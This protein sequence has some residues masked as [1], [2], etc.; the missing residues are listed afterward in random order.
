MTDSIVERLTSYVA[1]LEYQDL[2]SE[3]MHQVKRLVID[4]MG[5]ALAASDA[6]PLR[7]PRPCPRCARFVPATLLGTTDTITPDMAAVVNGAMV[8]YLD[9][10]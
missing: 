7:G 2:P 3:A 5:C 1:S 4:S 9:P 8:R 6:A 10:P